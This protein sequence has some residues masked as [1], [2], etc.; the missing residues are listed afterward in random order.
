[1]I[2]SGSTDAENI[3][4]AGGKSTGEDSKI[5][6]GNI[7]KTADGRKT[8][9]DSKISEDNNRSLTLSPNQQQMEE[10][11]Y[12]FFHRFSLPIHHHHHRR[13][14]P[15]LQSQVSPSKGVFY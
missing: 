8:G 9:V 4:T 1:V 13:R 2:I 3:Q 5:S 10:P 14:H 7:Q 6:A 12:H 11:V 15:N